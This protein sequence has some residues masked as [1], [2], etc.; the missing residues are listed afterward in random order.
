M[1]TLFV[2]V[3]CLFIQYSFAVMTN[4]TIKK[5]N[6]YI[7]EVITYS[8]CSDWTHTTKGLLLNSRMIQGVFD[9]ANPSTQHYWYYPD[10]KTW[11][12]TRNVVEFIGN[13]SRWKS[14]G[15]LAFTVG[16][17]GGGPGEGY[18]DPQPWIVSAFDFKT[19]ALNPDYL[20]RL[21][22]ILDK[23]DQ[24]GMVPIVQFFYWGQAERF[25]K[26]N[27]AINASI[28]NMMDWFISKPYMNILIDVANECSNH[29]YEGTILYCSDSMATTIKS[30][31]NYVKSK[32]GKTNQEL[33]IYFGSSYWG[34]VPNTNMIEASD[35][36][37]LHGNDQSPS[38]IQKFMNEMWGNNAFSSNPKP[39][40]FN[41]DPNTNF[42]SGSNN[43]KTAIMNHASWGFYYQGTND[44]KDGYQSPP[45]DWN[46][47]TSQKE[48]FF[49]AAT[50]YTT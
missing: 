7:N 32:T 43:M 4:L 1:G 9:D 22:M 13:M 47:D 2:L 41:E 31:K 19:G 28:M 42:N 39:I 24:L 37:L 10:T 45:V 20:T 25:N 11:N 16:L 35:I 48:A 30:M 44:Y 6:F 18:P 38:G 33:G 21:E 8:N 27:K 40:I 15:V 17:Q 36:I 23:A 12:A 49:N 26:N 34:G 5:T 3:C 50:N 29:N 14:Y 46:V